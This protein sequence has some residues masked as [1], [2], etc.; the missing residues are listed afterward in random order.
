[1]LGFDSATD[2]E[3]I[4]HHELRTEVRRVVF[5]LDFLVRKNWLPRL[6]E[7]AEFSPLTLSLRK[8]YQKKL[9]HRL[10]SKKKIYGHFYV[11]YA[12]SAE[13]FL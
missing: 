4:A 6:S 7:Y 9:T 5:S 10:N 2:H 8:I 3:F 11:R 12:I 1:M 13:L